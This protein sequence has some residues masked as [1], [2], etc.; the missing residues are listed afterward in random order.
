MLLFSGQSVLLKRLFNHGL[1][2]SE[3]GVEVENGLSQSCH[4][5]GRDVLSDDGRAL[6]IGSFD[7][8]GVEVG[9]AMV[10]C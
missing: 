9:S 4:H 10:A 8:T 5:S 6:Q 3:L 7:R 1:D 2:V